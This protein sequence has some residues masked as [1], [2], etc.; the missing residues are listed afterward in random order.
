MADGRLQ[1]FDVGVS[2]PPFNVKDW[3]QKAAATDP[4]GRYRHG[5]PPRASADYAFIS[6][7]A[8]TLKP[9]RGRMAVVVSHGVLFRSGAE[10]QIRLACSI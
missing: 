10:L 1:A 7:M 4:Y 3:G 8:E 6:H 9:G 5:A 2:S